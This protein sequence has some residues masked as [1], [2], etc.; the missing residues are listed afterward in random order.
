MGKPARFLAYQTFQF[1]L[2][3]PILVYLPLF[4][5]LSMS[6][7]RSVPTQ[8]IFRQGRK[9]AGRINSFMNFSPLLSLCLQHYALYLH[10]LFTCLVMRKRKGRKSRQRQGSEKR[11]KAG[12]GQG[13]EKGMAEGRHGE[14]RQGREKQRQ[15][16]RAVRHSCRHAS[17]FS[18][19]S[20]LCLSGH[21][22]S[23]PLPSV[24]MA[25]ENP[26]RQQA[27]ACHPSTPS[28]SIT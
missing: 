20:L 19:L 1:S 11:G 3:N 15:A 8:Q 9:G 5:L 27:C 14:G 24:F 2:Q 22:V 4:S 13:A 23:Q 16:G 7:L 6:L 25:S 12:R 21:P 10:F 17:S 26:P 18:T 28:S